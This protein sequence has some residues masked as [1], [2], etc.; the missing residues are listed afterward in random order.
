VPQA[1]DVI[2]MI[3]VL[4]GVTLITAPETGLGVHLLAMMRKDTKIP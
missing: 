1:I 3:R 4:T 2:N